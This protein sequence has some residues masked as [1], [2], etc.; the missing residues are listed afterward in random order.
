MTAKTYEIKTKL[1]QKEQVTL[2]A[3]MLITKDTPK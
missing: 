1:S 2:N 3:C